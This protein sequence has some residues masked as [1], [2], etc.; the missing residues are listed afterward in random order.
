MMQKQP[1][2][3]IRVRQS[4]VADWVSELVIDSRFR[5]VIKERDINQ[6]DDTK[7]HS[8]YSL[9]YCQ[10][11]DIAVHSIELLAGLTVIYDKIVEIHRRDKNTTSSGY[12]FDD[13]PILIIGGKK[14]P[15]QQISKDNITD[16]ERNLNNSSQIAGNSS[17]KSKTVGEVLFLAANPK[18]T[19]VLALDEEIRE[20]T[21]KIRL[22]KARDE[23]KIIS[24]W[25]V[26]PDDL[27]QQLNEHKPQVVHFSGHGSS[28]GELTLL[29]KEG[30]ATA[31]T[32]HAL[33][34]LFRTLKDNI[35]VV[36]LNAC[37]SKVQA[38]AISRSIDF[39]IGMNSTITDRAAVIFSASFYR[40]IGFN[41]TIQEAF[42]QAKTAMM[43]EGT[44]EE[45][46]PVLLVSHGANSTRR[47]GNIQ[48]L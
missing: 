34:A 16:I 3:V 47:I 23:L 9:D 36:I 10:V 28:S 4:K 35:E 2:I 45:E 46:I 42:D 24:A 21:Q 29:S 5:V 6:P 32:P 44:S 27:L 38:Q 13:E 41:R 30:S 17:N 37:Y 20:I 19:S 26:R 12:F 31:V 14:Y 11:V 33:E 48:S 43:L 8:M 1:E 18:H 7:S 39:V 40:A 22:S 15:L 25:A